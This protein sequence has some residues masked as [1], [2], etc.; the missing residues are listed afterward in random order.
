MLFSSPWTSATGQSGLAAF[1][2][3]FRVMRFQHSGKY[4]PPRSNA[5]FSGH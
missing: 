4:S 2:S 1:A 5:A 3:V